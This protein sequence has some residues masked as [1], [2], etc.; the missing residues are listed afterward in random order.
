MKKLGEVTV[1]P[2]LDRQIKKEELLEAVRDENILFAVGDIP[3]DAAVIDAANGLKFISA[4]HGAATFVDFAA[5]TRRNVPV[6]GIPYRI[7]LETTAEFT[8]ALL[9]ATAWRIPE[10]DRFLRDGKWAQ[11]QSMAFEGTRLH[12]NTLG[13]AGMGRIGQMVAHRAAACN[14]KIIYSKRTQLS[15]AEEIALG[16]AQFR[17]LEELFSEADFVVVTLPL[18]KDTKGL[19]NERLLSLMKP[20][21]VFI[22]TSR[23]AVVDEAALEKALREGR[24][25]GVG[26]DVFEHEVPHPHP[27]PSEGFKS[28][29]NVVFT[30]HIG[31]AAVQ[32]RQEMALRTVENIERFLAGERPSLVFNPEVYGEAPIKHERLS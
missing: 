4:M 23:G 11:N 19:I 21:A 6:A 2:R 20:N 18:T 26:L 25:R 22:N 31:S 24:I 32:T 7:L 8:F 13:V 27:G 28:L 14:M 29:S 16:N 10:A 17:T 15:T 5:A 30:P 1:F 9:I 12:G 3:F